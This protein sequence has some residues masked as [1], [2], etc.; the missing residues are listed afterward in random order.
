MRNIF[1]L[2][3]YQIPSSNSFLIEKSPF[4]SRLIN[5]GDVQKRAQIIAKTIPNVKIFLF[6]IDP[7]KRIKSHFSM[8]KRE[9]FSACQNISVRVNYI[10]DL[11]DLLLNVILTSQTDDGFM[12]E[13]TQF[14][15]SGKSSQSFVQEYVNYG[16]F[17]DILNEIRSVFDRS[18][19]HI[20]DGEII[21]QNPKSEFE[22]LLNFFDLQLG[23]M[24]WRFN[25]DKGQFCLYKPVKFCL[26]ANKGSTK[27]RLNEIEK[28]LKKYYKEQMRLTF[29]F[30]YQC[31]ILCCFMQVKRFVWMQ[32][33]FC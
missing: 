19:L 27:I 16:S 17:A 3:N 8:C 30:I 2:N 26:G 5:P 20:V 18:L 24:E 9:S 1:N 13:V 25:D 23:K 12:E 31:D 22:L 14:V 11:S 4:Y 15:Q 10:S 21:K 32:S 29:E 28:P 7:V 6:L 33:Y